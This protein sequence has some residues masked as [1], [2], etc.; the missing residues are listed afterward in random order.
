MNLF[1][2]GAQLKK[3]FFFYRLFN[4]DFPMDVSGV[5]IR[6]MDLG[7]LSELSLAQLVASGWRNAG[8]ICAT[9]FLE[10][11]SVEGV[12]VLQFSTNSKKP[13]RRY[14]RVVT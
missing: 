11:N 3:V 6:V 14:F 8:E 7:E 4:G 12:D 10:K 5:K 1:L 2:K 13:Y 9:I